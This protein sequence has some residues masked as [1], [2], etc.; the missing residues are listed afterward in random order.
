MKGAVRQYQRNGARSAGET[1]GAVPRGRTV[2]G[3]KNPE[4]PRP[5]DMRRRDRAP[6]HNCHG[7]RRKPSAGKT[8]GRGG[9]KGT[10]MRDNIDGELPGGVMAAPGILVPLVKVRVLAG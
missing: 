9:L 8:K 2:S 7:Q 10:E 6:L 1:G 3:R 4:G 5:P